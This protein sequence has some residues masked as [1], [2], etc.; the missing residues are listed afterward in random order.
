[1]HYA[2]IVSK[3]DC[4]KVANRPNRSSARKW[5]VL[6]FYKMVTEFQKTYK[7]HLG[8]MLTAE[9]PLFGQADYNGIK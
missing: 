7:R 8:L 9:P 2:V 1:M 5:V 6:R 3:V 4:F